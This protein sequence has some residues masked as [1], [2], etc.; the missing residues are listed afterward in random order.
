MDFQTAS[1]QEV[2]RPGSEFRFE[3]LSEVYRLP[4]QVSLAQKPLTYD[5]S[6]STR[7]GLRYAGG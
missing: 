7:Y 4:G 2:F 3:L 5:S 6:A 1:G